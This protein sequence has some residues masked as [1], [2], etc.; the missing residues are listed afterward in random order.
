M[1]VIIYNNIYLF[2]K[3]IDSEF[4]SYISVY[5]LEVI[6]SEPIEFFLEYNL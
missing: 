6:S 3:Q 2:L 4:C 5:F 1:F